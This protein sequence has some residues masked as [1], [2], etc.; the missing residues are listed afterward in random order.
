VRHFVARGENFLP[1][2]ALFCI[3]LD[4]TFRDGH[5]WWALDGT[6]IG[7]IAN[8]VEF[9]SDPGCKSLQNVGSGLDLD[10]VNGKE[11]QHFCCEKATFFKYFVLDFTSKNCLD[12]GWIGLSFKNSGCIWIA[13][14][15]SPL[16]SGEH[17]QNQHWMTCRIFASLFET[18]LDLGNYF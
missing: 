9:G 8:F 2:W 16:I 4:T 14:Y 6:W 10:W 13:K 15:D 5:Q 12:C 17:G 11:M 3:S 7:P 1:R 18:G